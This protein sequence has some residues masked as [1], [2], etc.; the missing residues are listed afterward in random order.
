MTITVNGPNGVTINFPDGTDA[1]TIHSVMTQAVS[2]KAPM[3][4]EQPSALA[5]GVEGL[6][7]GLTFNF[8]DELEGAARAA[9]GALKGDKRSFRELYDEGVA[10]PRARIAAAKEAHPVAFGAGELGGGLAM[11]GGLARAGI[12]GAVSAAAGRGMGARTWAGLREG[13]AYGGLYNAGGAE[14][15]IE[16]RLKAAGTGAI[17]G[18]AV[19]SVMPATMD[20]GGAIASRV[21]APFRAVL[22]PSQFAG[23]KVGEAIAR[24]FT[25]GTAPGGAAERFADRFGR[26][27]E[28]NPSVR[29]IDAG[30]EN[31]RGIVRAANNVPNEAREGARR[32]LDARQANQY[33]RLEEDLRQGFRTGRNY[34]DSIDELAQRMDDIG[35]RAIQPALRVET[36]MTPQLE[37]VLSRPTMRGI[38]ENVQR[39]IADEGRPI[40]FETRT[41]MLH[42]MK[43]ELDEQIGMSRR[44]E[45]MGNRPQAGWDTRTLTIL[46]RDLLN[47]IDNPRYKQGLRQYA[48]QGRL[49]NAAEDGFSAFNSSAPEE[50]RATLRN[51]ESEPE[52]MFYRL[53]AMRAII[54]RVRK[55]N[56]NNDR[57][58]GVFSSPD[59]Q[60]KLRAVMP[61]Q[62]AF[63]AFQR[64]LVIEAKMADSRKALQG[65]S[66]TAKQL[67]EGTQAGK[68]AGMVSAVA[69][70]ASGGLQP[71]MNL[72]HQ[73]YNRF[74]GLTPTVA[75]NIISHAMSRDPAAVD[76]LVQRGIEQ[77]AQ[78]PVRR[79]ARAE[80][81]TS[82]INALASQPYPERRRF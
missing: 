61:D 48:G 42:R 20:V 27:S 31:V 53:G 6:A 34:Y 4:A 11:P 52:R 43:M 35:E 79:A 49:M 41:E 30:G 19:G 44:A 3:A 70:A 23:E 69:N 78:T 17:T 32:A 12:R 81:I 10:I 68:A 74:T 64:Q 56:A 45:Q 38:Q 72:L 66:T 54:D 47:A 25:S 50:I 39:K 9:Y 15:G 73:G 58:D 13:A 55:G 67:A 77:A 60:M 28:I 36:P 65:N 80:A 5:S 14:G 26:M 71:V 63:R 40:G 24:D 1:E 46:K 33:A 22:N 21:A 51:M 37:G 57:T 75:S 16:D 8:G 18:A 29:L 82:G 62:A 7:Q 76:A 2:G 59:I